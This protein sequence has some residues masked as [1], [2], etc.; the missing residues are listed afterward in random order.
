MNTLQHQLAI[1]N[2]LDP[3]RLLLHHMQIFLVIAE[4]G[5]STY[6]DL[7]E[8]F[9]LSNASVSRSVCSLGED[10]R[11]RVAGLGLVERYPDPREG[12]RYRVRLTKKGKLIYD[13]IRDA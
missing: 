12:R 6:Q 3:G 10:P 5:S 4:A 8:H 2:D 7:M 9:H 11:H 13:Q 1:F